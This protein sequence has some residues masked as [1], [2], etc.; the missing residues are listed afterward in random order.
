MQVLTYNNKVFTEY[1]YEKEEEFEK[2]IVCESK[3]LFGDKT[4]FKTLG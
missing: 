3:S 1:T 2:D 4:N